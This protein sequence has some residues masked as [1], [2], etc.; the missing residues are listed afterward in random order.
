[1]RR[2]AANGDLSA[3]TGNQMYAH[4]LGTLAALRSLWH[5]ER[6]EVGDAAQRA[7]F[8]IDAAQNRATGGW[9][10]VPGDP[11]GGDTS[12]LGWQMMALRSAQLAGLSVNS[13]TMENA[14]KW[15]HPSKKGASTGCSPISPT[16]KPLRR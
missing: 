10:Y 2:Q 9:R 3:G 6:P 7:I 14:K 11:T 8:F 16:R 15:L 4:A 12:V 13:L 5:D 1:M